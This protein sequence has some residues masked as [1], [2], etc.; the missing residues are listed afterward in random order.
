MAGISPICSSYLQ[1]L[2]PEAVERCA[3]HTVQIQEVS[4]QTVPLP[5]HVGHR[6][7]KTPANKNS[8]S[9]TR[10]RKNR[11]IKIMPR[12]SDDSCMIVCMHI[13]SFHRIFPLVKGSAPVFGHRTV[14]YNASACIISQS[15]NSGRH[16]IHEA[17]T[18]VASP[19]I[20]IRKEAAHLCRTQ[21]EQQRSQLR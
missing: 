7:V 18:R 12:L 21:P 14:I 10:S 19:S 2:A 6:Y 3:L 16:A 20:C 13:P 5:S 8:K 1:N 4:Q 11:S 9:W 15:T 17:S